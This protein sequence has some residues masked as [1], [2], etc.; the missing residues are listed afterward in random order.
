MSLVK[1]IPQLTLNDFNKN[2]GSL[3]SYNSGVTVVF[4]YSDRCSYCVQAIPELNDLYYKLQG[5]ASVVAYN[6]GN[7]NNKDIVSLSAGSGYTYQVVGVPTIVVFTNNGIP[8]SSYSG[9]RTAKAIEDFVNHII[10]SK[11][12]VIKNFNSC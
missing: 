3:R 8:C 7:G 9:V 2:C 4:F 10:V 11:T 6:I 5:K 1:S 12:C